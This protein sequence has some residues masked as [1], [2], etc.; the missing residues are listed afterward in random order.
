VVGVN[1]A[2]DGGKLL[3]AL[4]VAF[5]LG[6]LVYFTRDVVFG[7]SVTVTALLLFVG[8]FA[9]F[10]AGLALDRDVLDVVAYALSGLSYLVGVGYVLTR[11][12][13]GETGTFL[14][15]GVSAALFLGLGYAVREHD[16]A[17]DRRTAGVVL[18]GTLVVSLA[19]VGADAVGGSVTYTAELDSETTAQLTSG[20]ATESRRIVEVSVGTVVARND[21]PFT[22]PVDLQRARACVVGVDTSGAPG[23]VTLQYDPRPDGTPLAGGAERSYDLQV[24]V[25]TPT[26]NATSVTYGIERGES[27]DVRRETPTILI[28]D[29]EAATS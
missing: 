23:R 5:A 13:V 6:A 3:Y 29:S 22:R 7:L 8:F 26:G 17:V 9:A 20:A 27:C 25:P 11:Y 4:G 12:A 15:L 28:V 1:L 21:S 14:L 2:V 16:L 10:V 19:L 18:V 24:V